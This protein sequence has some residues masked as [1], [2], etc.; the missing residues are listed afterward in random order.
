MLK[1]LMSIVNSLK[2]CD[3]DLLLPK[4]FCSYMFVQLLH[5]KLPLVCCNRF[6]LRAQTL[7]QKRN[8]FSPSVLTP[9]EC[10][11][12]LGVCEQRCSIQL[13]NSPPL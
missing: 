6:V 4:A 2:G 5:G 3:S 11:R 13:Q 10:K 7:V 8:D 12:W 1:I 9:L